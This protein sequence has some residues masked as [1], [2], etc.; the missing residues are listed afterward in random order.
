MGPRAWTWRPSLVLTTGP[1][2]ATSGPMTTKTNEITETICESLADLSCQVDSDAS[3][4]R[5]VKLIG[6]ES[7][8]G[9]SYP[10]ATLKTAVQHY[11][12]TPVNLDHPA[13]PHDS[14][15]VR[16]RIGV[17]RAARFVEGRGIFGDFHFNPKHEAAEQ[18]VWDAQ[19]N[20]GIVG[21]SHNASLHIG[22]KG[23]KAVVESIAGVRSMDLVA[24]PATTNGFFESTSGQEGVI[25]DKI[26]DDEDKQALKKIVNAGISLIDQ[27]LWSDDNTIA[28]AKAAILTAATDLVAEVTAFTFKS[29]EGAGEADDMKL[30]EF[31][32]EQIIEGRDDVA[33]LIDNQNTETLEAVTAERDQLK[34]EKR[35]LEFT[36]AVEAEL[37]ASKLT[38]EQVSEP[39]RKTLLATEGAE[40]RAGLIADREACFEG[41]ATTP[42]TKPTTTNVTEG[43]GD[44]PTPQELARAL[45][46]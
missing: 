17:I 39:F 36:A 15:S 6:F 35:A 45:R 24:D 37:A 43:V 4:I 30:E 19:N 29:P 44:V 38:A 26:A 13:K 16:D 7:R 33:K 20:P 18:V 28:Q 46:A 11:E 12:N 9:R 27:A 31:T 14:R 25:D 34:A 22:R 3:V 10:A 8:N 21:F 1:S 32:L 5:G 42:R 2:S 23:G 40:D 41:Q